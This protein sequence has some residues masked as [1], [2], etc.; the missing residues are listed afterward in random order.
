MWHGNSKA[1]KVRLRGPK[2]PPLPPY[3]DIVRLIE[4]NGKWNGLDKAGKLL[5]RFDDQTVRDTPWLNAL[6][7]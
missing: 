5:A 4:A 7:R 1:T 3:C 6:P 2:A